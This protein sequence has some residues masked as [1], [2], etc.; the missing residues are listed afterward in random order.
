[1]NTT[2]PVTSSSL[3]YV[4]EVHDISPVMAN[5]MDDLIAL[6]PTGAITNAAL[7][8]VPDWQSKW[9]LDRHPEF[10][11]RAASYFGTLVLHGFN[12]SLGPDLLNWLLYRHD[13]RSEFRNLSAKETTDRLTS[14][15]N[16]F[17]SAFGVRPKWFCAPRWK[18]NSHLGRALASMGFR[19]LLAHHEIQRFEGP[20]IAMPSLS[21]DEGER[22]WKIA[23]GLL[24]RRVNISQL[25]ATR[26]PFRLVLHPDDLTRPCTLRQIRDV[27]R[28]LETEGWKSITLDEA[29]QGILRA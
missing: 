11:E 27:V 3:T 5:R 10:T 26:R 13:N 14:G 8:I 22:G 9:P 21:F 7:L 29:S 4:A 12:H 16:V 18:G 23:A 1:M 24:F 15:V 28:R 6:L 17:C 2:V 25:L 20:N 19:G